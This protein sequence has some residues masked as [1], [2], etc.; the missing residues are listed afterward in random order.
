MVAVPGKK[1][2]NFWQ[3]STVKCLFQTTFSRTKSSTV[4]EF[5]VM[6]VMLYLLHA[7]YAYEGENQNQ[8]AASK[9]GP[10]WKE[11]GRKG[12]GGEGGERGLT[13][14]GGSNFSLTRK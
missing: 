5:Q 10:P 4:V 6:Q 3:R 13:A 12:G 2:G 1:G 9:G 11:E 8:A 14:R 7:S